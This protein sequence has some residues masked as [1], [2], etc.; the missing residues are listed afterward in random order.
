MANFT[1]FNEEDFN[2]V[3]S[4]TLDAQDGNI[5]LLT[6]GSYPTPPGLP[7][8]S[9]GSI[10]YDSTLNLFQGGVAGLWQPFTTGAGGGTV[11]TINQGI[12]MYLS[13]TPPVITTTGIIDLANTTV[14]AGAYTSADITVDAQGRLTAASN[15]TSIVAP[16]MAPQLAYFSGI[17]T[18]SSAGSGFNR[19]ATLGL[20]AL[21]IGNSS[22][23]AGVDSIALGSFCYFSSH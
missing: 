2:Y 10:I 1:V 7:P 22:A 14:A 12:S 11:T 5:N 19:A 21:G 20:D 9:D 16:G 18:V 3:Q 15:G 13:F 8:E 6:V 4:N 23:A 17:S